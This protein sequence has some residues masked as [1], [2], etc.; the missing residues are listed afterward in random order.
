MKKLIA[1][2]LTLTVVVGAIFAFVG[3]DLL[4]GAEQQTV[5]NV[6]LNP[7]VEFIL[8]S[9]N[10]V[11]SVNAL[12]E[13]GNMIISA[14]V[15]VGLTAE[16]AT[17]LF[18]KIAD[19]TGFL[20]EANANIANNDI[21]ISI[22]G[23]TARAAELFNSVKAKVDEY[24]TAENITVAINQ[25]TAITRD[26]LQA[27][28][29]QC[30]PYLEEAELKAMQHA[31]L[32]KALAESRK[33]TAEMYSQELKNAYYEAKASALEQAKLEVLKEKVSGLAQAG[34][35]L[36]FNSYTS[37]TASLEEARMAYLVSADSDYQ[38]ALASLRAK[39]IEYLKF[40]EEVA[41]MEP[42][43]VT[44]LV[45]TQLSVLES[46]VATA[47]EVLLSLGETANAMLDSFKTMAATAYETVIKTIENASVVIADHLDA[48]S[49]HQQEI[50]TTVITDF[51]TSYQA[52]IDQAKAD[53]EA[54][55]NQLEQPA[56]EQT[57]AV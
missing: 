38:Q 44:T 7:Q 27:L 36:A 56:P 31:E 51:E 53:W 13:E 55:K 12:N 23:N 22:S 10:K 11:V 41:T 47:E 46:T 48:I 16:E 24:L 5:M 33:E 9:D 37:A 52:F 18:I 4:A 35:E 45:T 26:Q 50:I 6:S 3:C 43:N 57:P 32:V 15:F 28:V 21:S 8:D 1:L 29:A 30:A 14:E 2:L 49:Q 42:S 40:R 34:L 25:A 39:K 17:Q 19:E 54:M 20:V